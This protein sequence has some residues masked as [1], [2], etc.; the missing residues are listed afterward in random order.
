MTLPDLRHLVQTHMRFV[1]AGVCALTF[2]RFGF[3]FFLEA[4]C[5]WLMLCPNTGPFPQT[6]QVFGIFRSY[7]WQFKKRAFIPQSGSKT[8]PS[9]Q[10]ALHTW[11]FFDCKDFFCLTASSCEKRPSSY[12]YPPPC[13]HFSPGTRGFSR[14]KL[15]T[16]IAARIFV[17]LTLIYKTSILTLER[18]G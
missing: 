4:L 18:D 10:W 17:C 15:G 1:P 14:P 12:T 9:N 13:T 6:S 16:K 2:C 11:H 3:H 8:N 5:E 7:E